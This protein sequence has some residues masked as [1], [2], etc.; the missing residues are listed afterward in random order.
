[1]A[2]AHD[3]RTVKI[4]RSS[5]GMLWIVGGAMLLFVLTAVVGIRL[6]R[7][8]GF[9]VVASI[10]LALFSVVAF[11]D[12]LLAR[13][14]L[15]DDR[16]EIYAN[17]RKRSYPRSMFKAVTYSKGSPVALEFSEGGWLDLPLV[18][19]NSQSMVN[20]LRAWIKRS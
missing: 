19:S 18:G 17:F 8:H 14:V 15:Y 2:K 20:T 7:G 3:T 12:T 5:R 16:L 9:L 1:M 4:F 13:V 10:G 11:I 6:I